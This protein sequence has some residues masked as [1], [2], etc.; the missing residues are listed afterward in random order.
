MSR[1]IGIVG[2]LNV[3]SYTPPAPPPRGRDI[4]F[5]LNGIKKSFFYFVMPDLIRHPGIIL[6]NGF[7]PAR[8]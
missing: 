4:I 5:G 1:F 2:V 7:P 3:F 6:H 8:E